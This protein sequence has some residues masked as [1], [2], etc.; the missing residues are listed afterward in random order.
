M[1]TKRFSDRA[2]LQL[3]MRWMLLPRSTYY[4]KAHPG[5]RGMSSSTH[6]LRQGILIANDTVVEQI[7]TLVSGPY[8]AYGYQS[9]NDELRDLGYVINKKKT[10]RLMDEYR[11]LLG[12]V[13]R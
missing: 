12:K 2:P 6:T 8:N 7:R 4:Y 11:L 5:P 9:V 13:I 10:Y 3:L 1:L